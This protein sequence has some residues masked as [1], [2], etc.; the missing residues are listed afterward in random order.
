L[1]ELKFEEI[2]PF[3]GSGPRQGAQAAVGGGAAA[4]INYLNEF[5]QPSANQDI[6][7]RHF[8]FE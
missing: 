8:F 4:I 3:S 2:F 6:I 1:E 7:I 5:Q